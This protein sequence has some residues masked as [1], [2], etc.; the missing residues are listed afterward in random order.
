MQA[1]KLKSNSYYVLWGLLSG[2]WAQNFK[3]AVQIYAEL[4][5]LSPLF[6]SVFI[7]SSVFYV[8]IIQF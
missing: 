4:L 8:L 2:K 5:G 1:T 6:S 3:F 7:R